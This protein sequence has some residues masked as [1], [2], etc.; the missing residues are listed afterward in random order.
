M[1]YKRLQGWLGL[2]VLLSVQVGCGQIDL[3]VDQACESNSDCAFA[4]GCYEYSCSIVG[5]CERGPLNDNVC[6]I[7]GACYFG[8]QDQPG[9]LCMVCMP[10]ESSSGFTP[11][12]CEAGFSCEPSTG[13]CTEDDVSV[14]DVDAGA[15]EP[16]VIVA[17]PGDTTGPLED[18][19]EALDAAGDVSG[20]ESDVPDDVTGPLDVPVVPDTVTEPSPTVLYGAGGLTISI[21][22]SEVTVTPEDGGNPVQ[23]YT[24]Q[25]DASWEVNG[26]LL[27]K[28]E[29]SVSTDG[30]YQLVEFTDQPQGWVIPPT[31]P[32]LD[33]GEAVV[34]FVCPHGRGATLAEVEVLVGT[35][36]AVEPNKTGCPTEEG[37]RA[38][39]L[40]TSVPD[41]L[42]YWGDESCCAE[43]TSASCSTTDCSDQVCAEFP[44]CC[45]VAWDEY[46]VEKAAACTI[47]NVCG[48]DYCDS[49][50]EENCGSC[51]QDC[52][53]CVCDA[54]A[55]EALSCDGTCV[56]GVATGNGICEAA[57]DCMETGWDAG[58]CCA[59]GLLEG[60]S[61]GCVPPAVSG[62]GICDGGLNCEQ[63]N[64]DGGDCCPP[65]QVKG[66]NNLCIVTGL[67]SNGV[68]NQ[69]LNCDAFQFDQGDCCPPGQA[70]GCDGQC[71]PSAL[72]GD[73]S[74]EAIMD[75][76]L[77][78]Y[79]GGDCCPDGEVLNCFGTGCNTLDWLGNGSCDYVFQCEGKGWDNGDCEELCAE[80]SISNC[81]QTACLPASALGDGVCNPGLQCDAYQ[82]DAG[83]CPIICQNGLSLTCNQAE[84]LDTLWINDSICDQSFLCETYDFDGGDCCSGKEANQLC[85]PNGAVSETELSCPQDC[86]PCANTPG[87]KALLA[88]DVGLTGDMG[89]ND[90]WPLTDV[91]MAP[92]G[93]HYAVWATAS[94][95]YVTEFSGQ[96]PTVAEGQ[97]QGVTASQG[98]VSQTVGAPALA[99]KSDGRMAIA[100]RSVSSGGV[101]LMRSSPEDPIGLW[102]EL[103]VLADG[104]PLS[105]R[106]EVAYGPDGDSVFISTLYSLGAAE[107][108]VGVLRIDSSGGLLS[109]GVT[110]LGNGAASKH[111]PTLVS[112]NDGR[113]VTAWTT[114]GGV[115]LQWMTFDGELGPMQTLNPSEGQLVFAEQPAMALLPNNMVLIAMKSSEPSGFWLLKVHPE[116]GDV[117]EE[118]F[119]SNEY[120][121]LNF[122]E[123]APGFQ[124]RSFDLATNADGWGLLSFALLEDEQTSA[125]VKRIPPEFG[126]SSPADMFLPGTQGT[127][128]IAAADCFDDAVVLVTSI[129]PGAPLSR[130]RLLA[131]DDT[132]GKPDLCCVAN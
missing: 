69:A 15:D 97:L 104:A 71:H 78:T 48:D 44:I 58:D 109:G 50:F 106:V 92:N 13:R 68:C 82:L 75:C 90:A 55:G 32:G 117:V 35:A 18:T 19:T 93:D 31:K 7:D 131:D 98:L 54:E 39:I 118:I 99:R 37:V 28:D 79:D 76:E 120:E 70:K 56:T 8:G 24:I 52:G 105:G 10:D 63:A 20:P 130:V 114:E 94:Q 46:C 124:P 41:S 80:G 127:S 22:A 87:L 34:V 59:D 1:S 29:G 122:A 47:C 126:A 77:A 110:A 83:D 23:V 2:T 49:Q 96:E 125:V 42:A 57:L 33:P 65:G 103:Q 26:Y 60:C 81:D 85:E 123:H 111:S 67:L 53:G 100:Y 12:V 113:A 14:P 66:C 25:G 102:T 30:P 86:G 95:L 72:L 107:N 45:E 62:N 43:H 21:G 5:I 73:G 88:Y 84:C 64:W 6:S 132:D 40:V 17:P 36:N 108:R 115:A 119:K 91:V 9:D 16:D 112:M 38:W 3:D 61:G 27:L 116:S 121:I 51:P 101:F 74:C 4:D 89:E 128:S 11:M 129:N